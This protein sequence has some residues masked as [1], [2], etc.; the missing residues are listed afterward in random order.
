MKRSI[1]ITCFLAAIVAI[2][3]CSEAKKQLTDR[4]VLMLI[5]TNLNGENWTEETKENW[6]SELPL[7]EW[8]GVKADEND[9]VT[10]LV[11]SGDSVKGTYPEEI[12]QLTELKSLTLKG[13]DYKAT[14]QP[15]PASIGDLINLESLTLSGNLVDNGEIFLPPVG[16][17]V[18]LKD[19]YLEGN[20]K[21]PEGLDQLTNL[22]EL[23]IYGLLGDIPAEVSKL[24][25]LERLDLR[26]YKFTGAIPSDIGNL[27][28]L[29]SLTI[30]KS[31]FIGGVESLAGTLPESIWDLE[32]LDYLFIRS[33]V[34]GGTLSPKIGNMK[35]LRDVTIIECGLTGEIPMEVYTMPELRKFSVY[36]NNL[37][38]T[39]SPEIGNLTNTPSSGQLASSAGIAPVNWFFCT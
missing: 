24:T 29:K 17:L 9:R 32:N 31:Q 10:E 35:K 27:K 30:D 15:F 38:G 37:T 4:E 2:T 20:A 28:N 16:K 3:G 12:G 14:E 5:F 23:R 33:V 6:G 19:L 1:F 7:N 18:N 8:S 36:E 34:N 39:L 13:G 26:G 25:L 11:L 22:T 21:A